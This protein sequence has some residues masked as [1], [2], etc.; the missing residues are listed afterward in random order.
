MPYEI[1]RPATSAY[2]IFT[3]NERTATL[4]PARRSSANFAFEYPLS[5]G[6]SGSKVIG[7]QFS[8]CLFSE[9]FKIGLTLVACKQMQKRDCVKPNKVCA[10]F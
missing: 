9:K 1:G 4:N 6:I 7:F 3:G 10:S 5:W 8:Y 2:A